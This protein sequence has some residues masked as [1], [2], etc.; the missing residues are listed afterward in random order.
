MNHTVSSIIR[1]PDYFVRSTN[2]RRSV[3]LKT[4]KSSVR[5]TILM[6]VRDE[7]HYLAIEIYMVVELRA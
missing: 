6:I 5:N 7:S 4:V 1:V 2:K 3:K